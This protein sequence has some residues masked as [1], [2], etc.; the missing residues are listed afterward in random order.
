MGDEF[1]RLVLY[2]VECYRKDGVIVVFRDEVVD[3]KGVL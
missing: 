1:S 3:F 2:E